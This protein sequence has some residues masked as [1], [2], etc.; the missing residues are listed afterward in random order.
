VSISLPHGHDSPSVGSTEAAV[1]T[2]LTIRQRSCLWSDKKKTGR[3]APSRESPRPK[4]SRAHSPVTMCRLLMQLTACAPLA[5]APPA[6]ANFTPVTPPL[7]PGT[8]RELVVNCEPFVR[9]TYA[10]GLAGL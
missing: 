6:R 4:F 5:A 2:P 7:P 8:V 3:A 10:G 9:V 1:A